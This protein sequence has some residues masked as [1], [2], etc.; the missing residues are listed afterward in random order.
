MHTITEAAAVFITHNERRWKWQEGPLTND[1]RRRVK[2]QEHVEYK[3]GHLAPQLFVYMTL[4][5]LHKMYLS[6]DVILYLLLQNLCRLCARL[7]Q[8]A[9]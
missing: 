7:K 8:H 6:T 5:V 3:R 9:S 4:Y 2:Q 1:Q